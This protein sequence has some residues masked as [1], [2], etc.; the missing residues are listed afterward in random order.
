MEDLFLILRQWQ[1]HWGE[2]FIIGPRQQVDFTELSEKAVASSRNI[3]ILWLLGQDKDHY[4]R[5]STLFGGGPGSRAGERKSSD[6]LCEQRTFWSRTVVLANWKGGDEDCMGLLEVHAYIYGVEV[7]LWTDHKPLEFIYSALSR[8]SA[9][10]E[11]LVLRLQSYS[12]SAKYLPG[13]MK[14][15]MHCHASRM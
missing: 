12:F 6:K 13:R 7:V 8:P 14:L 9:R 2:P 4:R 11:R 10:I 3:V 1:R 5:E 15:Q